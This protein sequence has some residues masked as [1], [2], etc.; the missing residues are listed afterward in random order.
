MRQQHDQVAGLDRP[1]PVVG[2]RTTLDGL[3]HKVVVQVEPEEGCAEQERELH[4][5][6]VELLP[7]AFDRHDTGDQERER[8]TIQHGVQQWDP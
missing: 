4:E 6:L 5:D 2:R 8:R 1:R 3:H 7:P